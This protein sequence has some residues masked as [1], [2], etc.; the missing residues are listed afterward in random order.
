LTDGIS[1]TT[2]PGLPTLPR[3]PGGDDAVRT[4]TAVVF[5]TTPAQDAPAA[6]LSWGEGTIVGRLLDQ[7][8][9]LGVGSIVVI[10]RPRWEDALRQA[11][12]GREQVEVTVSP[13][14]AEDLRV[15]ARLAR[16]R[17]GGIVLVAA[18]VVT[19]MQALAKLIEDPRLPTG[20]LCAACQTGRASAFGV[21]SVRGR[22]TSASS[23]YHA[24]HRPTTESLDVLKVAAETRMELAGVADRLAT[25]VEPPLETAWDEEL[26]RKAELERAPGAL[27]EEVV[28]LVLVG[29]VRS[30]VHVGVSG[31]GGF[32]WARPLSRADAADAEREITGYDEERARLDSAVK[33]N[34]GF[35]TTFFVSPYSK[36]IAGWAARRGFTPN[37]VTIISLAIG[38][39]AAAAFAT[40]ERVGLVAGAIL[41][42]LSFTTDCVDG[43]LARYSRT[44]SRLGAWLDSIFDRTKEYAVYAGLAIGAAHTGDPVWL[45]A[46]AALTV[47]IVRHEI[48]F[49][50]LVGERRALELA[51]QPPL[52]QAGDGASGAVDAHNG[53]AAA[54]AHGLGGRIVG[55]LAVWGAL[56]RW[57]A[58]EWLKKIVA[59]PIGERFAAISITAAVADARATF[60]VLLAWG[61]FA[62]AYKIVGRML[63]SLARP[64]T[65]GSTTAAPDVGA[66]AIYRDDGPLARALGS[67][68]GGAIA[69]P[70]IVLVV[71]GVL[72]LLALIALDG[73]G[74]SDGGAG[75]AVAWF[76]LAGGVS[77][78]S[79]NSGP[80]G[81]AVI[82]VLRLGE[83]AGLLWLAALAGGTGPAAAF[84]LL[85][86]LA[87]RNYDLMYRLRHRG[88]PTSRWV[89]DLAGGW[90][91]RLV[92]GW[93]LLA[94]DALPAGFFALAAV[95]GAVFV[96]ES[97]ASWTRVQSPRAGVSFEDEEVGGE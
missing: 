83:Y 42:Q 6:T 74:A 53:A 48:D 44:F 3:A 71:A 78:G 16:N 84:A 58:I 34:D 96:G 22:I 57:P 4:S 47:Q 23:A 52:E 32:F 31:L 24:V 11:I 79:P 76:V 80:F 67:A 82:P 63:R 49:T 36:H 97:I 77:C 89:G 64:T 26:R 28:P 18:N 87:F 7:L 65:T 61:G 91:G 14:V 72:P 62:T 43:Q 66:L 90:E 54:P 92:A 30:G 59:F 88:T 37:Q 19:H 45:L 5:A 29:L 56:N 21:R 9:A 20:A 2:T 35:F 40:G 33:A 69:L 10:T 27:L 95:L 1:Q 13:G 15:I 38:L 46:G 39:L 51:P 25:L 12:G 68:L 75:L 94:A 17:A 70:S 8:G 85:A 93:A 55:G 50:N 60:V 86:A 73:G 41:L 81:W